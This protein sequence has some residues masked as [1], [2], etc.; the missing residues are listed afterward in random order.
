MKWTDG[1]T[2]SDI[3]KAIAEYDRLGADGVARQWGYRAA[4]R[5]W[6][7]WEGQRYPSKAIVGIAAEVT[8]WERK[9]NGGLSSPAS[10]VCVLRRLG[11]EV[12]EY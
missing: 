9:L 5:Y 10:A 2:C 11:F 6:L 1:I 12:R 3:L 8:R 4:R 7:V